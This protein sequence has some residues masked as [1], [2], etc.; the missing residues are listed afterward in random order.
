ML[1]RVTRWLSEKFALAVYGYDISKSHL[2]IAS[3][4][5]SNQNINNYSLSS[6]QYIRTGNEFTKSRSGLFGYGSATQST[7]NYKYYSQRND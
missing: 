2:D 1:G 7:T 5:Y 6:S 4:Y 3:T